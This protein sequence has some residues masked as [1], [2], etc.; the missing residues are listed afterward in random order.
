MHPSYSYEDFVQS[1]KPKTDHG[2]LL[3]ELKDGIFKRVADLATRTFQD[4]GEVVQNNIENKDLI[5]I[6]FFLSK[7]NT[8]SEKQANNYFGFESNSE[9]FSF[10]GKKYNINP[11]SVKNHRDKIDFLASSDRQGWRP[12]N[13]LGKL[14]NTELWP[15]QEIFEEL[16]NKTFDEMKEIVKSIEKKANLKK[17]EFKE[18]INYVIILDEINRANISKVFG[19]LVTLI[20]EDKRIGAENELTVSLPSGELFGVPPNLYIIGTMNTADKSIAL[21]DIALRRRFQFVPV[22]PDPNLIDRFGYGSDKNLKKTFLIKLN[23]ALLKDK[24]VDFQIG[25]AYF[26]KDSPLADIINQNILPLL[27]E[28]YRN[29]LKTVLEKMDKIGFALDKDY[30]EKT[31]LL[32]YKMNERAND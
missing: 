3:F 20:E 8:K 16:K 28:Y 7:F 27:T 18:N 12:H 24:G 6:C 17:K 4:E 32:K 22:Y 29:D 25:H 21:V 11:N 2:T 23:E 30:F 14:D 31:G 19:E 26:L 5:R 1:L 15:Y 13:S 10:L 9:T